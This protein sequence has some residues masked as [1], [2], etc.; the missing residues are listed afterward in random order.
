[1]N[2]TYLIGALVLICMAVAVSAL[3]GIFQ[4][5]EP[6]E[7]WMSII[8]LVLGVAAALCVSTAT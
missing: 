2:Q 8:Q 7:T 1:M 3:K 5:K 4:A 6:Y